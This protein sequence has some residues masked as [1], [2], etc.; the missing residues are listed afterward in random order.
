MSITQIKLR[1]DTAANWTLRNPILALG[2]PGLE[3]DTSKVKYGDGLTPWNS[4][5]Y[6]LVGSGPQGIQGNI[7]P[8]GIQGNVGLQGLQGIQGNI[9]PQG[10]PGINGIDGI[11]GVDGVSVVTAN[12]TAG[13]NIVIGLSN[14][15]TITTDSVKGQKGDQ[16]IQGIQGIQGNVGLQGDPG[17]QGLPGT[18]IAGT[19]NFSSSFNA[20]STD[21]PNTLNAGAATKIIYGSGLTAAVSGFDNEILTVSVSA[22]LTKQVYNLSAQNTLNQSVIGWNGGSQ[23][24]TAGFTPIATFAPGAEG[25]FTLTERGL[26]LVTVSATIAPFPG[27]NWPSFPGAVGTIIHSADLNVPGARSSNHAIPGDAASL[28]SARQFHSWD[29]TYFITCYSNL[30]TFGLEMF[31]EVAGGPHSFTCDYN[32]VVTIE[33]ISGSLFM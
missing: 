5:P 33:K 3:L 8:Q 31:S 30:A 4:I 29:D 20:Q 19:L 27:Q 28:T 2:E 24:S 25:V 10:N 21:F 14:N 7:G 17:I 18:P 9:G 22:T 6:P 32:M 12:V 23:Y 15:T 11:N 16:G 26:Y 13:G 1:R